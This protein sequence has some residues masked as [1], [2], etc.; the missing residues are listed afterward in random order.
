M[1][2]I[3]VLDRHRRYLELTKPSTYS[4]PSKSF[5][6]G[7]PIFINHSKMNAPHQIYKSQSI[8]ESLTPPQTPPTP[9][10]D[11]KFVHPWPEPET[12]PE[13]ISPKF[14]IKPTSEDVS[15]LIDDDLSIT[16]QEVLLLHGAKQKY[17]H[18]PEQPI[19]KLENDREM[20]VEVHAVGL[21]PIDWKAP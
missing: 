19:P 5:R 3:D 9:E 18:T 17:V 15:N 21:N 11:Y 2:V 14:E 8:E 1:G 12:E 4:F 13:K 20:L 16:Y 10:L 7:I 6:D